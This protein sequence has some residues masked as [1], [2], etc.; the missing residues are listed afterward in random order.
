MSVI[1]ADSAPV[2]TILW[3]VSTM[4]CGGGGVLATFDLDS[5]SLRSQG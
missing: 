4:V 3:D 5:L 1:A 2:S